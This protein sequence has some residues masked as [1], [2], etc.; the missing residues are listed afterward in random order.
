MS[1]A[2]RTG[3]SDLAVR[4]L[5][6]ALGAEVT[7]IDLGKPMDQATFQALHEAWMA[8]LVLVFPNQ[9]LSDQAQIA[10][11]RQFGKLEEH[12]QEIIKS[13][14]EPQIFRVSNVDDDGNLMASDHPSVAQISLAQRW[15]TD[16]SYRT[17]PSMGS[18]LHGIEITA[19]GGETWFTNMYKVYEAL[20]GDIKRRIAGRK[21][22]HDFGHLATL[23]P[24]KPLTEAERA[25]MPPVWQPLV[26]SHPVTGRTSLFISPIYNDAVEDMPIDEARDLIAELTELSGQPEFVYRHRWSTDD[27]VMWDNRCTMHRVTPYDLAKRRVMHR[28]TI[29]GDGPVL[30]A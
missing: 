13:S 20:D 15:H 1:N 19:E 3:E 26:R 12:H 23:A 16:S 30:A 22:C 28:T 2:D 18:I 5:H 8:H 27:V 14:T 17:V 9:T 11:A 6:P 10:F 25:A 24:I 29:V 7:G 21:A 4:P